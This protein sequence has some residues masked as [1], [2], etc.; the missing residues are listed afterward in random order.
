MSEARI[1]EM[2]WCCV[3]RVMANCGRVLTKMVMEG[4]NK[5]EISLGVKFFCHVTAV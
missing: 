1:F 5:K 3:M 2:G 4:I